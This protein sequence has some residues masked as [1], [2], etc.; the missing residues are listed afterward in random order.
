MGNFMLFLRWLFRIRVLGLV[1]ALGLLVMLQRSNAAAHQPLQEGNLLQNPGFEGNYGPWNGI[2]EIQV[3][4]GWTPWWYEDPDHNP[5]YFR[6]EYKRALASVFPK[7][8]FS[9]DSAQQ[10]FTFHASHLAGM[11]QQVFNVT[12]GVRYRFTIWAQVWSSLEDDPVTSVQPANPH[13]QIGIDP[14]GGWSAGSPTVIWSPEG[15]MSS[16]I[17]QWA[18]LNVEATAENSIITVMMRT[19]PDFASKHNDMYWDN[20][21]LVAVQPPQPT[22]LPTDTPGPPVTPPIV[23]TTVL[24]TGTLVPP[25]ATATSTGTS[26]FTPAATATKTATATVSPALS[27]AVSHTATALPTKKGTEPA[28]LANVNPTTTASQVKEGDQAG[29][30]N[31]SVEIISIITLIGL[32]ILIGLISI[33]VAALLRGERMK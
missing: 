18:P 30:D 27:P 4:A 10:W 7:R 25:T 24:P 23:V 21:S 14:T 9:G 3:A 17:D 1:C 28:G 32:A 15:A 19:N 11:Y 16:L 20:A 29:L 22:R 26:T 13:L 8:V 2:P 5:A 31:G 12:P 6:P 33:A